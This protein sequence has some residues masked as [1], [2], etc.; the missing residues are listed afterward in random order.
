MMAKL[1]C[2]V[3][4]LFVILIGPAYGQPEPENFSWHYQATAIDQEHGSFNAPYSGTNSLQPVTESATSY[5]TTLFLGK[6]LWEGGEV[7][8]DPEISGGQGLS[9]GVGLAGYSN[10]EI[11]RISAPQA[12]LY[13]ARL[14]L[15]QTWELGGEKKFIGGDQ[16]RLAKFQPTSR[17][18]LTM[19]KLFV[20]DI[21]DANEYSNDTRTQFMNWALM[22]NGAWDFP[23]DTRGYTWGV[24]GEYIQPDWALRFGSFM[25][26]KS[27]IGLRFDYRVGRAHG[28][29]VEW[30][31]RYKLH[32]E[33]GKFRLIG[34]ANH[35]RMGNYRTTIDTPQFGMDITQSRSY[36]TKYGG[37]LTIEQ[38]INPH[39]GGFMRLGWND[40]K[41]ETWSYTEI[42]QTAA[43]G[44][45]LKG[46]MWARPTDKIGLAGAAN[47]L[48]RDHR[49]YL[50]AGGLGP[51]LGDGALSYS[52]EQIL[53]AY[54]SLEVFRGMALTLDYQRIANPG[55]NSDRGPVS[56]W[57]G[58]L[59][60]AY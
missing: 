23:A 25:V 7:Y 27:A 57:S 32:G 51:M 16:N 60:Y 13:M 10:G 52:P 37:G 42:D 55:Y 35:A 1:K 39:V 54:Y 22:A 40:G 46:E 24:V 43:L 58:R 33:P 34:F 17:F 20:M 36:S 8:F 19:G 26:P 18:S 59:H 50:A 6:K 45:E 28:E 2:M 56:I 48:S 14:F 47:F 11:E 9:N 44:I 4:C 5:T 41:T 15:R 30:E 3:S 12:T 53:E 31:S 29:A 21:F 49:D 38:R